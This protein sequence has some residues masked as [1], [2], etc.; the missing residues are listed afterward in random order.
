MTSNSHSRVYEIHKSQN[1][2]ISVIEI[3]IG[4][5]G[6]I[7]IGNVSVSAEKK[8]V[9]IGDYRYQLIWKKVYRSYTD[10]LLLKMYVCCHTPSCRLFAMILERKITASFLPCFDGK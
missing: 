3:G 10:F 4:R 7:S 1:I 5:Y 8:I 9:F 6:K 2:V